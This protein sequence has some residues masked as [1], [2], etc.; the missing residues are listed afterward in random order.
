MT[1]VLVEQRSLIIKRISSRGRNA[2]FN[3]VKKQINLIGS[4]ILNK[5]SSWISLII[6]VIILNGC[7][8]EKNT[9][10]T[11]FDDL[12]DISKSCPD[13]II[14]W[15]DIL[16]LNDVTYTSDVDGPQ[17][18]DNIKGEKLGEVNYM[19]ADNACSYHKLRNGDAAYLPKGTQIYEY[20]G[21]SPDFRVIAGDKVYQVH[22][23]KKA[24]TISDLYN[25]H[26]KVIKISLESSADGRHLL[27]FEPNETMA[28]MEEFLSLDY[29]GF[30]SVYDRIKHSNSTLLRIHLND[31]TSFR[32]SYWFEENIINPGAF[33]TEEMKKIMG[34]IIERKN[35]QEI[36]NK[37]SKVSN[38]NYDIAGVVTEV[39]NER[40][41]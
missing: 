29:V 36:K 6:I 33:G 26:G 14:E 23:N 16:M 20:R 18:G 7:N 27:D 17:I 30:D 32:I 9:E 13:G 40:F 11:D 8:V 41:F 35:N 21:Y 38:E 28:F 34:N 22:D 4:E 24:K 1:R 25:I 37:V 31:G 15:V 3:E 10:I 39:N 5:N 2:L 12:G 19:M